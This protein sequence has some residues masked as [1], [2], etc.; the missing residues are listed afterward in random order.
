MKKLY[1]KAKEKLRELD[2]IGP[3]FKYGVLLAGLTCWAA[4]GY[5]YYQA[6][7]TLK[8]FKQHM[9]EHKLHAKAII[10]NNLDKIVD[11][12]DLYAQCNKAKYQAGALT[13]A[14]FSIG[15]VGTLLV[16]PSASLIYLKYK[17]IKKQ[18]ED[19]RKSSQGA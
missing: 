12:D 2:K 11:E 13:T 14:G 15:K 9:A 16:I 6:Y 8:P 18:R 7:T 17:K 3:Y 5:L 10:S 4:G 19:Q 1:Q